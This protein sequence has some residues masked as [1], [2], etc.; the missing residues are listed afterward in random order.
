[1]QVVHTIDDA[2][3]PNI[4]AAREEHN[5]NLPPAQN[6]A[7]NSPSPNAIAT[8][9]AFMKFKLDELVRGWIGQYKLL[10]PAPPPADP[11]VVPDVVTRKQGLKALAVG[12]TVAGLAAPIFE[13]DI[14]AR[15]NAMPETTTEERLKKYYM[16]VEFRDAPTWR[17]GN[18]YFETMVAAMGI[19]PA[20]RDQLLKHAATFRD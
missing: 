5:A 16:Q 7:P 19:T 8:N 6:A 4:T 17:R 11:N 3:A 10:P 13:A 2:V 20:Q 14:W 18:E 1:M 9:E 15:I 12:D